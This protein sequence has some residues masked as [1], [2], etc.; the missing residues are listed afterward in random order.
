MLYEL[1]KFLGFYSVKFIVF[2]LNRFHEKNA[3]KMTLQ[4]YA[5]KQ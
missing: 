3:L 2:F 4:W 5:K 1:F